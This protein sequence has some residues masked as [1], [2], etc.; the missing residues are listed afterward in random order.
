[1]LSEER[2]YTYTKPPWRHPRYV[3]SAC[4]SHRSSWPRALDVDLVHTLGIS[5]KADTVTLRDGIKEA[6]LFN[7]RK[8]FMFCL[9]YMLEL[10]LW[11]SRWSGKKWVNFGFQT[12]AI[13]CWISIAQTLNR[14]LL[15]KVVA[16]VVL[17]EIAVVDNQVELPVVVVVVEGYQLARGG[18]WME[19][20]VE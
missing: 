3:A 1:M 2:Q 7:L 17:V 18:G 6:T 16:V 12:S 9:S 15:L 20:G 4:F 19:E 13:V 10:E 5:G 8:S 11:A 14:I